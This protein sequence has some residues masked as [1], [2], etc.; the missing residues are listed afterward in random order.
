M[1]LNNPSF[2]WLFNILVFIGY[3]TVAVW[4]ISYHILKIFLFMYYIPTSLSFYLPPIIFSHH[5]S[6]SFWKVTCKCL[7]FFTLYFFFSHLSLMYV[8]L[9]STKCLLNATCSGH[10]SI[11]IL[12]DLSASVNTSN[13][14]LLW[15]HFLLLD[16]MVIPLSWFSSCISGLLFLVP[17]FISP[18]LFNL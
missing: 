13:W 11:Y 5:L 2:S 10:F 17:V 7:Y 8:I 1:L 16:S 18:L 9:A 3:H 6:P 15:K 12:F 4:F 14:S